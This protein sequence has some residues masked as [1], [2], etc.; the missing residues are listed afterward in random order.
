M[1]NTVSCHYLNKILKIPYLPELLRLFLVIGI[2][3][4]AEIVQQQA[5]FV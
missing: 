1:F 5:C 3:V 4:V 2:E